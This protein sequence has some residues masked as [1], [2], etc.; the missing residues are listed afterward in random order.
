MAI[1]LYQ[2]YCEL[3][4][5][6]FYLKYSTF[7]NAVKLFWYEGVAATIC[8]VLMKTAIQGH[9]LPVYSLRAFCRQALVLCCY[10]R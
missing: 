9:C 6:K 2:K 10:V 4:R 7:K 8:G 5:L 1:Q 3:T